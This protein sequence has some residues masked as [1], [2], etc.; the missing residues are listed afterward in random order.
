MDRKTE[1]EGDRAGEIGQDSLTSKRK[2][3]EREK[4]LEG[5]RGGG[6]G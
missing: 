4:G 1:G 5:E 2:R 6:G 3:V